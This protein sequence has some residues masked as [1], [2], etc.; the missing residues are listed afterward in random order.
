[1]PNGGRLTMETIAQALVDDDHMTV[2]PPVALVPLR[3]TAPAA[4]TFTEEQ[5]ALLKRTIA[6]GVSDDELALFL[7]VC[8]RTGLDPFTRQ[9]YAIKRRDGQDEKVTFQTSIDG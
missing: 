1:M 3:P 6:K 2:R 7:A 5:K 4:L 9:I 8:Q